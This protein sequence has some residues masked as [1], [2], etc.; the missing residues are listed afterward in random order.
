MEPKGARGCLREASYPIPLL[1]NF[2]RIFRPFWNHS[3]AGEL[4]PIGRDPNM[5]RMDET[6]HKSAPKEVRELVLSI[7]A[8]LRDNSGSRQWPCRQ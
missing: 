6:G 7:A 1:R 8:N 3:V 2:H 4:R 5:A